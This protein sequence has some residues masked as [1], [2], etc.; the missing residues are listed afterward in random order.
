LSALNSFYLGIHVKAHYGNCLERSTT[1]VDFGALDADKSI[2]ASLNYTSALDD[3]SS[4]T[5]DTLASLISQK[6]TTL[7]SHKQ[8]LN[9][10]KQAYFQSAVL[11]TTTSGERRVRVCN[12]RLPVISLA[13]NVYRYGDYEGVVGALAK[14]GRIFSQAYPSRH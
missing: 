3:F 14:T 7:H 10:Q 1:D 2:Y 9:T 12:L 13:G 11:Y 4:L 5:I 6:G 8:S